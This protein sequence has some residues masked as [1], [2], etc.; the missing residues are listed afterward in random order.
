MIKFFQI[1]K[2]KGTSKKSLIFRE[3]PKKYSKKLKETYIKKSESLMIIGSHA[4]GKSRE[5]SKIHKEADNIYKQDT[6]IYINA[7]DPF[8]DWYHQNIKKK[9][10]DIFIESLDD[11]ELRDETIADIKKQHIKIQ[12]LINKSHK[13]ILFIDDID[14][15]KGKKK[16]TAKDMMRVSS[17]IICTT[18]SKQDIDKTLLDILNKKNFTEIALLS[19]VSYDATNII[20]IVMIVGMLVSGMHELAILIMAGR[21]IVKG[22][23]KK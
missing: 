4:S 14:L 12:T 7:I 16:E 23:E 5:I 6:Q 3:R 19:D 8:T 1:K 18:K 9:D 15:L 11:N 21:Y 22:K 13:S 10:T 2:Q 17:I 20:F